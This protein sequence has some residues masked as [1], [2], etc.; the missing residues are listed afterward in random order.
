M[1]SSRER[2]SLARILERQGRA[3]LKA[4]VTSKQCRGNEA[5]QVGCFPDIDS[6]IQ[7]VLG[8]DRDGLKRSACLDC[9]LHEQL[10][11]NEQRCSCFFLHP[12]SSRQRALPPSRARASPPLCCAPRPL[13]SVCGGTVS[14][15]CDEEA[16]KCWV[17]KHGSVGVPLPASDEKF[18]FKLLSRVRTQPPS[19]CERVKLQSGSR[20]LRHLFQWQAIPLGFSIYNNT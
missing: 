2:A 4:L 12:L 10:L 8:Q 15:F 11:E 20:V 18:G 3:A 1:R 14:V 9:V 7:R 16:K 17:E 5:S 19:F 6:D 13:D